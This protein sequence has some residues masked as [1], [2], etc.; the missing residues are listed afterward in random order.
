MKKPNVSKKQVKAYVALFVAMVRTR[1]CTYIIVCMHLR[2][3]N[4]H[5]HDLVHVHTHTRLGAHTH[6]WYYFIIICLFQFSSSFAITMMFPFAP[7][8][9]KFL[10]PNV[11]ETDVGKLVVNFIFVNHMLAYV[12]I[13][14]GNYVGILAAAMFFG[15][16]LA[17]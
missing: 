11:K 10:L 8:L 4:T 6:K 7:F 14:V 15:R 2:G 17:R 9:V 12:I 16:F 5:A 13:S 1:S 3:A